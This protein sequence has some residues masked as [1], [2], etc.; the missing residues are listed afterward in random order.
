MLK[1]E[2]S[3]KQN[4][5]NNTAQQQKPEQHFWW[6]QITVNVTNTHIKETT[7]CMKMNEE[8]LT[9]QMKDTHET[10]NADS[11]SHNANAKSSC[12]KPC[13]EAIFFVMSG[14][15]VKKKEKMSKMVHNFQ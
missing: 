3:K 5:H 1:N 10:H 8:N 2:L 11:H 12:R 4:K 15:T 13:L 7:F 6:F 9:K 14:V